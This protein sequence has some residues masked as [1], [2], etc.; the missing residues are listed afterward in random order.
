MTDGVLWDALLCETIERGRPYCQN[1]GAGKSESINDE[2]SNKQLIKIY[3]SVRVRFDS[4]IFF[5]DDGIVVE[6]EDLPVR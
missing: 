2:G 1:S 5:N 3:L 6:S 4:N